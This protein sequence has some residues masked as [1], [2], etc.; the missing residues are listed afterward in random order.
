MTPEKRAVW[1]EIAASPLADG[2]PTCRSQRVLVVTDITNRKRAEARAGE[3]ERRFREVADAAPV[4]I[5]TSG[6]DR[7]RRHTWVNARWAEFR[8]RAD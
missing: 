6:T 7:Q 8:G 2:R 4:F 5:W 1:V 3:T